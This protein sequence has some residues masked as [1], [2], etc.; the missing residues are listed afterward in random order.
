MLA[1]LEGAGADH[2]A[3]DGQGQFGGDGFAAGADDS[4]GGGA[5]WPAAVTR[6][7]VRRVLVH[8]RHCCVLPGAV[9]GFGEEGPTRSEKRL[10]SRERSTRT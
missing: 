5:D 4:G 10:G 2:L 7:M 3:E 1:L 8:L 6:P 9:V